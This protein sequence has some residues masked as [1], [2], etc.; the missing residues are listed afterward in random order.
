MS[1]FSR[2]ETRLEKAR[3]DLREAGYAPTAE[4]TRLIDELE[5]AA[6]EAAMER[7]AQVVE[8]PGNLR[9]GDDEYGY[10]SCAPIVAERIR[11]L[12]G[13]KP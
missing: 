13:E 9:Q 6:W 1:V 5:A 10:V 11:A 7:A 12:K 8:N 4:T 3:R 2:S